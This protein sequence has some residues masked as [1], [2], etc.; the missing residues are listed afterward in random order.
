MHVKRVSFIIFDNCLKILWKSCVSIHPGVLS[1]W[2]CCCPAF[3]INLVV[4]ILVAWSPKRN[5]HLSKWGWA[6]DWDCVADSPCPLH[7][8]TSSV[9]KAGACS[10]AERHYDLWKFGRSADPTVTQSVKRPHHGMLQGASVRLG[11]GC[12]TSSPTFIGPC[13]VPSEQIAWRK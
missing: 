9:C 10:L 8:E 1:S 2:L 3:I 5:F 12:A 6:S 7:A 4:I 11:Y 13:D